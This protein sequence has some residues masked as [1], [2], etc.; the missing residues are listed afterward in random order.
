MNSDFFWFWLMTAV[1]LFNTVILFW[2]G[3]TVLLNAQRRSG[4][5]WL[6]GLGLL[7]GGIFFAAHTA[8]LDYSIDT[9][10]DGLRFWWYPGWAAILA[11]PAGWYGLMLWY[12]G[13]WDDRKSRLRL[14]HRNGNAAIFLLV[15]ALAAIVTLA[16]PFRVVAQV[17]YSAAADSAIGPALMALYPI[18]LLLCIGL[19]LDAL[20]HPNP[21]GRIMGDLARRRALPWLM[22]STAVQL[23]VSWLVGGAMLWLVVQPLRAQMPAVFSDLAIFM[24][25]LELA[26]TVLVGMA[27]IL[28]GKAIVSYEIFT[29]KTL[30][31]HGLLRQWRSVVL[32]AAT[33]G[34]LVSLSIGLDV[35]PIYPLLLTTV[36]MSGFFALYSWQSYAERERAMESLRPFVTSQHLYEQ[37]L[38]QRADTPEVTTAG[39]AQTPFRALCEGVL[40][41]EYAC[42]IAVGSLAPL[43]GP[44]L[45]YARDR[46]DL[47]APAVGELVAQFSAPD[48]ICVPVDP[49]RWGGAL[50]AVPL[51]SERG[52]IG[53]L[54]LGEKRD[55]GLYTQEEIEI[56]RASSERLIDMM[57]S[58]A[59]AQRLMSLQRR[60]IVESQLLDRRTRRALHDDVLPRLHAAVLA[61]AGGEDLQRALERLGEA[62]RQIADLL[63]EMPAATAP[64]IEQRGLIGA[65]RQ[66]VATEFSGAF[67]GVAWQIDAAAEREAE[68]LSPLSGEVVFYAAREAIRN[69][70]RYGRGAAE[71][72]LHLKIMLS[73]ADE[74][75]LAVEDD[76]VGATSGGQ[77]NGGSGQG[78]ALHGTMMAV[79]GG[80]LAVER[81]AEQGTRVLLTL[82]HEL[83]LTTP[84]R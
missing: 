51:W 12:A 18:F 78:L 55:G 6:A 33:Y 38:S 76:G 72:P 74:L 66:V 21:S 80:S 35:Q 56:A 34:A 24:G 83:Q 32:L 69:A 27:V 46:D 2:L 67:D 19:S 81:G 39:S 64:E 40:S 17:A 8:M 77:T 59:M 65:L 49:A 11:L 16:N 61:L 23:L 75:R 36:L 84:G 68:A 30:P 41:A 63:R 44:P 48:A 37:L 20:R 9:L 53:V 1:S 70:A 73:A 13:Y 25:G 7:G 42:L 29:G 31:R 52:L 5:V 28:A 57:A 60:Q 14:R 50:W 47:V 10:V 4:G 82:P 79:I 58:A 26:A 71:A 22:A 3:L 62:H 54:L 43:A 15:S 45:I